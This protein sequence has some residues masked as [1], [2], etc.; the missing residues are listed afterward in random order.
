MNQAYSRTKSTRNHFHEPPTFTQRIFDSIA[1]SSAVRQWRT[2]S[3]P[4]S[5]SVSKSKKGLLRRW[6]S[7]VKVIILTWIFTLY[8]GERTLFSNSINACDWRH[9]ESWVWNALAI[10]LYQTSANQSIAPRCAT[11]SCRIRC[12]PPI[13]RPSYLSRTTMAAVYP[14]NTLHRLVF[15]ASLPPDAGEPLPGLNHLPW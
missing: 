12:R 14:Y 1:S 6:L 10:M 15:E 4:S 9:W 3:E 13:G 2:P 8:W 5:G 7:L 11:T